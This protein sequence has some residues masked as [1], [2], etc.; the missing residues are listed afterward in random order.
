MGAEAAAIAAMIANALKASGTVVRIEP[1][2]F[3]KI[4]S[5]LSVPRSAEA[6]RLD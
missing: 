3:L 5:C 4:L 6:P 2:E 1:E